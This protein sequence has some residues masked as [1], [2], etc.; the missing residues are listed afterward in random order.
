MASFDKAIAKVLQ[1]E[2]G[3]VFNPADPGGETKYGISKRSYPAYNI[4]NISLDTAKTLYKLDFWP[5]IKGD[6][7]KS[8]KIANNLLD[9]AVNA[10]P[11]AA[12]KVVQKRLTVAADGIC[13]PQTIAA[14]NQEPPDA[15][16][17][18]LVQERICFYFSCVEVDRKKECFLKGWIKR[19]SE[20]V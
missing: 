16:N 7:I 20:F 17:K 11:K 6:E 12:I 18:R 3:Y 4:K 13:G 10:G 9:F 5:L 2:G 15:L 19:A 14:I 1:Y 8:Q